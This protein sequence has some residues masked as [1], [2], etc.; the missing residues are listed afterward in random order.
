LCFLSSER[1]MLLCWLEVGEL[2][3]DANN[4]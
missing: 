1:S 2:E 3:P 4:A